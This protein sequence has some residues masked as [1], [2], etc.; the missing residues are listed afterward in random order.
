MFQAIAIEYPAHEANIP[1]ATTTIPKTT[2]AIANQ[3]TPHVTGDSFGGRSNNS[4]S[5]NMRNP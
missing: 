2:A 1:T 4:V 5:F 3:S